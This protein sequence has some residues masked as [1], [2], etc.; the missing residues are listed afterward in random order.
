MSFKSSMF[1]S[2]HRWEGPRSPATE[3]EPEGHVEAS[4]TL[5]LD[6]GSLLVTWFVSVTRERGELAAKSG[7][8]GYAVVQS[9]AEANAVIESTVLPAHCRA[10]ALVEDAL[11]A[12]R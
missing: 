2:T 5:Q 8:D 9:I 4:A 6:R 12:A 10:L 3:S 11:T 1:D 7:R